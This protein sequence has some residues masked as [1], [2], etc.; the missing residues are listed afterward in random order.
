[1]CRFY[2]SAHISCPTVSPWQQHSHSQFLCNHKTAIGIHTH[3][4]THTHTNTHTQNPHQHKHTHKKT[5]TSTQIASDS[6]L[7]VPYQGH[8]Q[9]L[10]LKALLLRRKHPQRYK[11]A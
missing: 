5:H 8:S 6:T 7:S 3:T 9:T 10:R 1:V 2:P 4:H 11:T